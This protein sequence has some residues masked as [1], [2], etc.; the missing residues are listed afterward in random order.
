MEV[1]A[2]EIKYSVLGQQ[3]K[4][5]D[6]ELKPKDEYEQ[7]IKRVHKTAY[8]QDIHL[9]TLSVNEYNQKSFHQLRKWNNEIE[10]RF[11][12]ID[13]EAIQ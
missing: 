8:L 2:I 1:K 9:V 4:L 7:E 3:H 6:L 5:Y 13:K 11:N 12:H 10:Q